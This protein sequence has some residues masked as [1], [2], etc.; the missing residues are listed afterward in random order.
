[1][2]ERPNALNSA[3]FLFF[4][5]NL[6]IHTIQTYPLQSIR[7]PLVCRCPDYFW[8][9]ARYQYTHFTSR[10]LH[11]RHYPSIGMFCAKRKCI[12]VHPF[13]RWGLPVSVWFFAC[14]GYIF[15]K[16]SS[17][18]QERFAPYPANIKNY[19]TFSDDHQERRN[20]FRQL[21]NK[22]HYTI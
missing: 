13:G 3:L 20:L 9:L 22:H 1:M 5:L 16:L 12:C 17:K 18:K 14:M 19:E 6:S 8:G 2:G 10:K 4:Q 21:Q 15:K 11:T 7:L